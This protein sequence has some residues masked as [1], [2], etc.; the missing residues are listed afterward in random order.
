VDLVDWDTPRPGFVPLTG[1]FKTETL[2]LTNGWGTYIFIPWE[3]VYDKIPLNGEVWR[4]GLIRWGAGPVTWG[5]KVH[6]LGQ[7]GLVR[8]GRPAPDQQALLQRNV[9]TKAWRKYRAAERAAT[10][11]WKDPE[12]GDPEF[13]SA[14]LVPEIEALNQN[15]TPVKELATL[16]ADAVAALWQQVPTM[17]EFGFRTEA[18]RRHYLMKRLMQ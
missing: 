7:F 8:W 1:Y 2:A 16:K 3:C 10:D 9:I 18:L 15:A 14:T 4:F 12:R 6:E 5:G 17:M 13:Y 11:Y